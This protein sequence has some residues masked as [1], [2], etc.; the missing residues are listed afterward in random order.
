MATVERDGGA[1]PEILAQLREKIEAVLAEHAARLGCVSENRK[2]RLAFE[3]CAA[4]KPRSQWLKTYCGLKRFRTSLPSLRVH[5]FR[6]Q[7]RRQEWEMGE[8]EADLTM[9][10]RRGVGLTWNDRLG[11][12]TI[13]GIGKYRRVHAS[14]IFSDHD[15]GAILETREFPN[16][17]LYQDGDATPVSDLMG[18]ENHIFVVVS[19]ASVEAELDW[20][21]AVF[22]AG[23]YL[24]AFD[25]AA[26][27]MLELWRRCADRTR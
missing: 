25:G 11:M 20:R 9:L 10:L 2:A 19:R 5:D 24:L 8:Y 17:L 4:G 7:H 15:C 18:R 16:L 13:K 27:L 12:L 22:E 23:K 21:L 26:L 14:E 3:R 1:R 6:E